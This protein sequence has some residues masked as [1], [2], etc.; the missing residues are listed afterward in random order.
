MAGV[1]GFG[2]SVMSHVSR[3]AE[4]TKTKTKNFYLLA[5]DLFFTNYLRYSGYFY[6]NAKEVEN[7]HLYGLNY[8]PSQSFHK[9]YVS[10]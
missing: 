6:S 10:N 2:Y 1:L 7:S 8:V 4:K 9:T 3:E 5:M